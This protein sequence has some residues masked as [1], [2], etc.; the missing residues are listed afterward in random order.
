M[1]VNDQ[2]VV[3][4]QLLAG[5]V[6]RLQGH[7][8]VCQHA[9]GNT[10]KHH[11]PP[12]IARLYRLSRRTECNNPHL[13]CTCDQG[14]LL[15]YCVCRPP[16]NEDNGYGISPPPP[17]PPPPPQLSPVRIKDSACCKGVLLQVSCNSGER[18]SGHTLHAPVA[19]GLTAGNGS[20]T[21]RI[22]QRRQSRASRTSC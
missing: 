13:G 16:R 12:G 11:L 3:Q 10:P 18:R 15:W 1:N 5:L 8:T 21:C 9:T 6:H 17:P 20:E 19:K 14:Y 2:V 7:L 22:R 4:T